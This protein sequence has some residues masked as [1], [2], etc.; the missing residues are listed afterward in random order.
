LFILINFC[1]VQL[2]ILLAE[3]KPPLF[4]MN[5]MSALYHIAQNEPPTLMMNNENQQPDVDNT[6][7]LYTNDFISFIAMCLQK[8]PNDRPT[9]AELLNVY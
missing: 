6:V 5:P 8:N 9:P 4:N 2:K 7:P 3:R 1:F